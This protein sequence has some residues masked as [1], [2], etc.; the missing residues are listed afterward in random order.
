MSA[1]A[2]AAPPARSAPPDGDGEALYG[3]VA[4]LYPL[5]RCL[6]G[7]GLRETL[8]RLD[9]VAPLTVHEVP[10]GTPMLD[11]TAPPEWAVRA[12]WLEAPDGTRV[13]DME[14]DGPLAVVQY[15]RPVRLRAPLSSLRAHLHTL[16]ERPHA[17]PYR[18]AYWA[19][20]W[21]LCLPHARL[22]ALLARYGEDAEV[23]VVVDSRVFD[24]AMS[25]GECVIPGETT[26]EVL[27][28]AH[29][30]HPALAND[31]AASLAVAAF[32]ARAL[33]EGPRRRYTYRFLFAPGTVGALAWLAANR[34]GVG[35]IRH[36]LVLANLGDRGS[37]T[38]KQTRR[39]TL[40][41][42][43]AVDRAVA[44]ALEGCVEIRPFDPFGYDERQYGSPGFDLPVGRLTRTPHGEYPEYHTSDDNLAL[45]SPESL[46][47]SLDALLR[48]C[49]A[50]ESG[51]EREEGKER[52]E[53][54]E[55]SAA[56][57]LGTAPLSSPSTLSFP[58]SPLFLNTQPYGEPQLGRRG[59]YEALGGPADT[60]AARQALMWVLNLSD[61]RH[62]LA[63]VAARSGL[64][65]D[66]VRA[67]ADRLRAAD[68]LAP[69]DD[70]PD[71]CFPS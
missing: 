28:S 7:E 52:K 50:L 48:V 30:C 3:L 1:A 27:I 19:E 18:T 51:K 56:D 25:Y 66:A 15:S 5:H 68:L 61:G 44:A 12:A 45:V 63:D 42:P 31:N 71:L 13:V 41:T 16:P 23:E 43:L 46:A 58:S 17:I 70:A 36:G 62:A 57:Q 49:D 24:G 64:P 6:T 59:L 34:E 29:A 32:L 26:D 67:A 10:T 39:G 54:Q 20:T 35:R 37:F 55:I 8:R 22:E 53:G 4:E 14:R 60:P 65:L 9:R 2:P 21:G 38:Y 40:D 69:L 33:A 11:W 47:E